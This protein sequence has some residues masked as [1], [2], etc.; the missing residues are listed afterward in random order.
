MLVVTGPGTGV[1]KTVVTAAIA[2]LARA[3]GRQVAVVKPAQTGVPSDIPANFDI[4]DIDIVTALSG[5]T[6][7]HEIARFPRSA[8]AGGGRPGVS[9]LPPLDVQAAA[10]GLHRASCAAERDLVIVEG[11]AGLLVRYDPAGRTI[12]DLATD[13]N[14]R[15]PSRPG[16]PCHGR[17]AW[18]PSTIR[19]SR[20]RHCRRAAS[21]APGSSWAAG[22]ASSARPSA[23]TCRPA[24]QR[25][26]F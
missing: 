26:G 24:G 2:A 22:R 23:R 25:G 15:G 19:H 11:L 9:G 6:D 21:R 4:P 8:V 14:G 20:A 10:G 12:A 13:L 18:A 3:A 1:G 7:T 16:A 17:R 5:V